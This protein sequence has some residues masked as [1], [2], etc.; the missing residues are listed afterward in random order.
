MWLFKSL[1]NSWFKESITYLLGLYVEHW[2]C[3][4][5]GRVAWGVGYP[6][7]TGRMR[8]S[9]QVNRHL[10]TFNNLTEKILI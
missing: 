6:R 1:I 3:K 10:Q 8:L 4:W 9:K 5:H 7:S 2:H